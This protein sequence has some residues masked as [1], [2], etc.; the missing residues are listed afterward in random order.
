MTSPIIDGNKLALIA[1]S[2]QPMTL[3]HCFICMS[4]IEILCK[5]WAIS[6]YFVKAVFQYV[7]TSV[8]YVISLISVIFEEFEGNVDRFWHLLWINIF[9][10]L[11]WNYNVWHIVGNDVR[12]CLRNIGTDN[13][14]LIS[15]Q[16]FNCVVKFIDIY[17][18]SLAFVYSSSLTSWSSKRQ[19]EKV[20]TTKSDYHIWCKLWSLLDFI[21]VSSPPYKQS[22]IPEFS[23]PS[24]SATFTLH[25]IF[26]CVARTWV[27][28]GC[29]HDLL[30][31]GRVCAVRDA[32]SAFQ[33]TH[34]SKVYWIL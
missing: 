14:A 18:N 5:S 26:Y 4:D 11:P 29:Q 1:A 3:H 31:L 9:Q 25:H 28:I 32:S 7:L 15:R 33:K 10:T 2:S 19:H 22:V 16:V 27:V 34:S 8:N 24:T 12:L 30:L 6:K 21:A 20:K 23:Q 17:W 13:W